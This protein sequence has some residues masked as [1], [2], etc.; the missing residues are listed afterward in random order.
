[1]HFPST[2]P[3]DESAFP[4]LSDLEEAEMDR[5]RSSRFHVQGDDGSDDENPYEHIRRRSSHHNDEERSEGM[6][7]MNV[8]PRQSGSSG[9]DSHVRLLPERGD[10][11]GMGMQPSKFDFAAMEEYAQT[12]REKLLGGDAAPKWIPDAGGVRQRMNRGSSRDSGATRGQDRPVQ[13]GS[14]DTAMERTTTTSVYGDEN[15]LEEHAE[16]DEHDHGPDHEHAFSPKESEGGTTQ[17]HRRRQRKLSQSNPVMRRQGKLAL[18]EGLGSLGG[19]H[20]AG[21]SPGGFKAPRQP[22]NL[23]TGPQAGFVPFTDA[24]PGHDRPYRFSFYSN[25]LP[26]TIHARSLAELPAEG[27]TFSDLFKG[28]GG[29]GSPGEGTTEAGSYKAGSG[30]G[31]PNGDASNGNSAKMSLLARAAG[32]AGALNASAALQK[33]PPGGGGPPAGSSADDDPEACTWWLDVLSPTD[34]EMRMLAKVSHGVMVCGAVLTP[35][36]WNPPI[37]NGRYLARG[38]TRKD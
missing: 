34:E 14:Y 36:L 29:A 2:S 27:Q 13:P 35:G 15:A 31:T 5:A 3:I 22:K 23:G 1:M 37:D 4:M 20:E 38:N 8:G 18:F 10:P 11:R 26:V 32:A 17:F 21:E 28:Q 16:V 6:M 9:F 12:E 33:G 25:A 30:V 19:G 7:D 24:A